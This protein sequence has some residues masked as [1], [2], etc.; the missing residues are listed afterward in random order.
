MNQAVY[1]NAYVTACQ[2]PT[3]API[4][5]S[6]ARVILC[7]VVWSSAFLIQFR[8]NQFLVVYK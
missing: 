3:V 8:S 7:A 5:Y 1:I 2:G 6:E 4:H